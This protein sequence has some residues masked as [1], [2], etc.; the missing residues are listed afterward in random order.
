MRKA[1]SSGARDL[2]PLPLL[3]RLDE[4]AACCSESCVPVS[5]QAMPRPS[6]SMRSCPRRRYSRFTSVISY[7]PRAEG[8]SPAAMSSTSLS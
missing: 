5:S 3:D 4:L 8:R 7:S 1:I 2:E 6:S